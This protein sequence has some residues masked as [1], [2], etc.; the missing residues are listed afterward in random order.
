MTRMGLS[1]MP[2][3][4]SVTP[5][6]IDMRTSSSAPHRRTVTP[7]RRSCLEVRPPA[8]APRQASSGLAPTRRVDSAFRPQSFAADA[9]SLRQLGIVL[10]GADVGHA[11]LRIDAQLPI[12]VVRRDAAVGPLVDA[13]RAGR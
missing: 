5:M 8:Q 11:A 12:V 10:V 9:T 13:R 6:A 2:C 1:A 3:R 7:A 4:W